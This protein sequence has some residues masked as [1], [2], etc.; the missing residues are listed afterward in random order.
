MLVT[1]CLK[2]VAAE[3]VVAGPG[4]GADLLPRAT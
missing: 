2:P 4:V 1:T 3:L